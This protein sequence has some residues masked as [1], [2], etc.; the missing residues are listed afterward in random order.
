ML[1]QATILVDFAKHLMYR[2][3]QVVI[4]EKCLARGQLVPL[5]I[6]GTH[7]STRLPNRKFWNLLYPL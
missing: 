4:I 5:S 2:E 1:L 6:D 7:Y 3:E